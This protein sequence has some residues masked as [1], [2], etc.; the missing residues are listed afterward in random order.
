MSHRRGAASCAAGIGRCHPGGRA[1]TAV[2]RSV[3]SRRRGDQGV[4]P[5][6]SVSR[7]HRLGFSQRPGSRGRRSP[8]GGP[9]TR[10][11]R[12]PA[13]PRRY[14]WPR[15]TPAACPRDRPRW[16][17]PP[18][19]VGARRRHEGRKAREATQG[20]QIAQAER[21]FPAC[22]VRRQAVGTTAA[23]HRRCEQTSPSAPAPAGP[24][25]LR[26]CENR[27]NPVLLNPES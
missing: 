16:C 21:G 22:A 18:A 11:C 25:P 5:A 3:R 6:T 17:R 15:P 24:D 9:A 2:L 23:E 13:R 8:R 10:G 27:C 26:L 20:R 19:A 7:Q 1:G 14:G 4:L 12:H